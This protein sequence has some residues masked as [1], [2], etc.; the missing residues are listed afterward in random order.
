MEE[1][2]DEL[3]SKLPEII[4]SSIQMAHPN[5]NI[6]IYNG[7][8]DLLNNT[9]TLK[10]KGSIFFSWLP[11][12]LVRFNALTTNSLDNIKTIEKLFDN[13][14]LI[15]DGLLFGESII[16]NSSIGEEISIEGIV[17]KQTVLGDISIPVTKIRFS[18]PL[19]RGVSA[20]GGRGVLLKVYDAIG[21]EVQTLVNE[22]LQPGTYEVEWDG[23]NFASGIYYYTLSAENYSETKKMVLIR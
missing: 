18:I 7:L 17:I 23:S 14:K 3:G 10:M 19:L 5:Q 22:S 9:Q 1:K 16:Y 12:P 20:D 21:R 15:I 4:I 6:P 11:F 2:I 8:F 13:Y